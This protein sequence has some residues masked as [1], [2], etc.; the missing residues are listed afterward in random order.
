MN[1]HYT[2]FSGQPPSQASAALFQQ[3]VINPETKEKSQLGI[4]LCSKTAKAVF[5]NEKSPVLAVITWGSNASGQAFFTRMIETLK[6]IAECD[7]EWNA[8]GFGSDQSLCFIAFPLQINGEKAAYVYEQIGVANNFDKFRNVLESWNQHFIS[9]LA[10][11]DF[12]TFLVL[13]VADSKET[14]IECCL[15]AQNAIDEK[16]VNACI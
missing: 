9:L 7:S 16:V 6:S 3:S 8:E 14:A 15:S 12:Q 10:K 2:V 5:T 1:Y 11:N 4:E 13:A